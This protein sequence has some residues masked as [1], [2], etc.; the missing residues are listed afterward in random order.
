MRYGANEL[1]KDNRPFTALQ[2]SDKPHLPL[3]YKFHSATIFFYFAFFH[4]K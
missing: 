3:Q 1:L 2:S 4:K